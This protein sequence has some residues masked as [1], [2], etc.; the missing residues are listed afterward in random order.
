MQ[1]GEKGRN[2]LRTVE[3][4]FQIIEWLQENDGGRVSEVAD[5]FDLPRSTTHNYLSTLYH[6][7]YLAKE[8]DEYRIS[9][10]FL[11]LGGHAATR[12]RLYQVTKPTVQK[13][14]IETGE[15]V[16]F[17]AEES[18]RGI[19]VHEAMGDKAVRTDVRIGKISYLHTMSA[20]KAILAQLDDERVR[21]IIDTWGLPRKTENTITE[22]EDLFSA[23]EKIRDRGY[24][25][26]KEE[27]TDRQ[28]A[29]GV[30]IRE[31][32][33]DTIGAISVSGPSH[34]LQDERFTS[35]VPNLLLGIK[36]EIHLNLA[37][38]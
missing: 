28:R 36:D 32:G 16:Q 12:K 29:V 21:Q 17:V 3:N 15:R 20:G 14:A 22:E 19:Y 10:S 8:G 38:S 33:S 1:D 5:H 13:I 2:S 9:L 37:H 7:G 27:R 6:C 18:G 31:P 34:R 23:L 26:N 25:V 24:A 30:A 4:A 35:E 11:C